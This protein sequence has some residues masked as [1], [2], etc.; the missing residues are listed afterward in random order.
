MVGYAHPTIE[1]LV[2]AYFWFKSFHIIGLVVWLAGLFY[3]GRLFVYHREAE[4]QSE[5]ARSILKTQYQLM[6]KRLYNIITTPGMVVTVGMAI[7]LILTEPHVLNEV[8]LQIKLTLVSL[9][10]G[11]H[12]Y[13]GFILRQLAAGQINFTSQQ[14]RGLNEVP[15]VLLL[16]IVLLAV[17]KNSLPILTTI[18]VVLGFIV[19]MIIFFKLYAWQRR[20]ISQ[21]SSS[22]T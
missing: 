8:W 13:C 18:K 9:L 3:L 16:I 2:M 21:Q 12:F 10:I 11:Y 22:L 17:F 7:A 6:E 20:K 4:E 5:P 1:V 15:T 19:A 14:L